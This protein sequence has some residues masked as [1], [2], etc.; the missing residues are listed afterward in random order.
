VSQSI[1]ENT[2]Q[3][4]IFSTFGIPIKLS[5]NP[6]ITIN[7]NQNGVIQLNIPSA[8]IGHDPT[9]AENSVLQDMLNNLTLDSE[10]GIKEVF[11]TAWEFEDKNAVNKF[12]QSLDRNEF[13]IIYS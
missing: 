11:Y 10:N 9:G 2:S 5:D 12:L 13:E 6:Q 4:H 8:G 1:P 7:L 3:I